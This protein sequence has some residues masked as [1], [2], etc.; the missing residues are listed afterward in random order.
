VV[1]VSY[2]AA[3]DYATGIGWKLF[4]GQGWNAYTAI[5]SRADCS[6]FTPPPGTQVLCES[7]EER[8]GKTPEFYSW[9]GRSPA[10]RLEPR[11]FPYSDEKFA[12]FA[13]AARPTLG[14]NGGDAVSDR[15]PPE[16]GPLT[17]IESRGLA[18]FR[19]AGVVLGPLGWSTELNFHNPNVEV[20]E[21][22]LAHGLLTLSPMSFHAPLQPLMDLRPFL[23]LSGPLALLSLLLV[24]A[25]LPRLGLPRA[26]FCLCGIGV[27][28][29][30]IDAGTLPRYAVPIYV[31]SVALFPIGVAAFAPPTRPSSAP[32][33]GSGA[34]ERATGN[35]ARS[36][37]RVS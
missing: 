35:G 24:L 6:R 29:A 1:L 14:D 31:L 16:S 5:A 20:G 33:V 9:D 17:E 25:A 2:L 36:R 19:Q 13:A 8:A 27:V 34:P 4:P 11:G 28:L 15:H 12:A 10:R 22:A 3:Q 21:H 18:I 23:R 7:A 37:A 30:W 26:I 32:A